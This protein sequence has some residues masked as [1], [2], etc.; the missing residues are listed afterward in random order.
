MLTCM[1][2][3]LYEKRKDFMDSVTCNRESNYVNF[4]GNKGVFFKFYVMQNSWDYMTVLLNAS[5]TIVSTLMDMRS[6]VGI[7]DHYELF[8]KQKNFKPAQ[9]QR[10]FRQQNKCLVRHEIC[11]VI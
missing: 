9:I 8:T 6:K 2:V 7:Q 3:C 5:M 1:L 11:L 4:H 10:I